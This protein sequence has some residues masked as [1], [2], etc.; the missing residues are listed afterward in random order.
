[1]K[2][3]SLN[4]ALGRT[5]LNRLRPITEIGPQAGNF[6]P[7]NRPAAALIDITSEFNA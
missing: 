6:Y 3:V 5:V 4:I 2:R 1:M 7:I